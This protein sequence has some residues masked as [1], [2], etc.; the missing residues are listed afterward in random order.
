MPLH[1]SSHGPSSVHIVVRGECGLNLILPPR[2]CTPQLLLSASLPSPSS[3]SAVTYDVNVGPNGQ[4][5]YD[6]PYVNAVVRNPK[7]HTVTQSAF[8]PPC[9]PLAGEPFRTGFVPVAP[10]TDPLPTFDFHVPDNHGAPLW[11]YCGQTGHCGQGMVF[12]I[13]PPAPPAQNSFEAFRDLAIAP[14]SATS[15][16]PDNYT[17]PPPPQ[18][19]MATATVTWGESTY[20][21][22]YTSYAGTPE[23][24]P[25]VTPQDHRIVFRP[26][27]HTVTQSTFSNPC[28]G[29]P[30]GFK[31][32]FRPIAADSA[33]VSTFTIKINDT[34]PIWATVDRPAIARLG[35]SSP[36]T[37]LSPAPT[38]SLLF[39]QLARRPTNSSSSTD[40]G[41]A[42]TGNGGNTTDG[43][44]GGNSGNGNGAG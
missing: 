34:A 39:Q 3:V 6:P 31:S 36:S 25:A 21:T 30:D 24:T 35:W 14:G 20:E 8:D 19:T 18:W 1:S 11:F 33:D 22:V 43:G 4:F 13:N 32:G 9:V 28:E 7:N 40:G 17:T 37:P 26:K 2:R 10:G 23:P 38:T 44:N 15:T 27:N 41:D 29:K 12:A 42:N 16:A 5:V